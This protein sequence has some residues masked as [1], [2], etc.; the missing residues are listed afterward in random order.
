MYLLLRSVTRPT[1]RSTL[2]RRLRLSPETGG[3]VLLHFNQQVGARL[4]EP[5]DARGGDHF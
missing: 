4:A 5:V 2:T 1:Y 3:Q